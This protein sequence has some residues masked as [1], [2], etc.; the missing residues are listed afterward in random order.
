MLALILDISIIALLFMTLGAGLRFRK[1]LRSFHTD[2]EAFGPLVQDLDRTTQRAE[3]VLADL[4]EIAE[5]TSPKLAEDADATQRL[6]TELDFMTK[7]AD[8]LADKLESAI[9]Q[10]RSEETKLAAKPPAKP[11]A[12]LDFVPPAQ[13]GQRRR[14][15]DLEQ[16][17][18]SLR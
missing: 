15:P 14:P 5:T 13:A 3:A 12:S 10:A 11:T 1:T 18:K 8:Q 17:L 6:L 4:K 7:R 2:N 16:R 9:S